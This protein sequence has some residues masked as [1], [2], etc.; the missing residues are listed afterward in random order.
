MR[1]STVLLSMVILA[2]IAGM[3]SAQTL[4]GDKGSFSFNSVPSGADVILDGVFEGETPLVVDVSTTGNPQHTIQMNLAGYEPWTSSYNGNPAA[5]EVIPIT[6][7]LVPSVQFG[8][9]RVSSNPSNAQAV[10]D[11]SKSCYTACTFTEIPVGTHTVSV[12]Y[13][14]YETYY[15]TVNVQAGV[16]TQVSATL[17]PTVTVGSLSVS[18]SPSGASVYVDNVYRGTTTAV[19][20]NLQAGS[21]NVLIVK[22]GYQNWQNSVKV[23]AGTATYVNAQLDADPT[24][25]YGTVSI[26]SNPPG[27]D[28][29]AD[30]RYVGRTRSDGPLVFTQVTPGTHSLTISKA[31]YQDYTGT[32]TIVAGHDYPI[33]VTLQAVPNPT[34]GSI[35]VNSGPSNAEVYVNNLYRGYS[36]VT[37][38]GLT[39]GSYTVMVKLS[40]YETW[41]SAANVIAGQTTQI[42][43]TLIQAQATTPV[44]TQ[45]PMPSPLMAMVVVAA[46]AALFLARNRS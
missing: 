12:Y 24:P 13:S 19:V 32:G 15:T 8:S 4:G 37:V 9:I 2:S 20:G 45:S 5:G 11:D 26:T 39:P 25:A 31:G 28:V 21:H 38:D 35:S 16:T 34:T 22:A 36:P 42:S 17:S 33:S 23:T 1:F 10:L 43:A 40:G 14:G 29:Y 3:A 27:A 18:S 30:G 7:T 44:P 6:A 46:G 41:Q